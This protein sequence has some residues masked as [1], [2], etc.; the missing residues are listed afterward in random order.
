LKC[1]PNEKLITPVGENRT[2]LE[3]RVEQNQEF[4]FILKPDE[5][6]I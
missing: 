4:E 5:K 1:K 2:S 3:E 6:I